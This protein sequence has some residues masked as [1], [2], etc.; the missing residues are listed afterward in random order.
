MSQFGLILISAQRCHGVHEL[1]QPVYTNASV[2]AGTITV[3]AAASAL[4]VSNP[5]DGGESM[6][7][8]RTYLP[9]ASGCG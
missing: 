9:V 7:L 4:M 5:S 2:W 6:G 3:S 1:S 8:R